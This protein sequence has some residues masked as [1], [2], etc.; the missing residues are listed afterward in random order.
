MR[1]MTALK[2]EAEAARMGAS[3]SDL[4]SL[5]SDVADLCKQALSDEDV[6]FALALVFDREDGIFSIVQLLLSIKERSV[7]KARETSLNF[8]SEFIEKV[9]ERILPHVSFLKVISFYITRV[10][11]CPLVLNIFAPM[12]GNSKLSHWFKH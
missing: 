7:V 2:D 3:A 6:S 4:N 11:G 9:G 10:S 1:C 8:V 5:I 12:F